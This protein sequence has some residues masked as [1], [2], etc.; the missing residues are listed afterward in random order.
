MYKRNKGSKIIDVNGQ[1]LVRH[2]NILSWDDSLFLIYRVIK[3]VPMK[4]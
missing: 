2:K 3:I 1:R 4:F